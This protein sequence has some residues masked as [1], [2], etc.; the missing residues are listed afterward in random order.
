MLVR[1]LILFIVVPFV[2][3]ALLLLLAQWIDW[4]LE[5]LLIV[6]TGVAG[7]LLA[8]AQGWR[9]YREIE[10]QL[11]QGKLPADS[12]IDAVLILLAG[13]LLVTPGILTDMFG[14]SLL[15]PPLRARYRRRLKQWFRSRF[16]VR[17]YG[18]PD[19][20]ASRSSA[21]IIDSQFIDSEDEGR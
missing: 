2:E 14:L 17:A 20:A 6:I 3:L 16:H 15:I 5:L 18:P 12:L 13:A 19:S 10:C 4:K 9:T 21:E 11:S 1:L 8:R 7:T